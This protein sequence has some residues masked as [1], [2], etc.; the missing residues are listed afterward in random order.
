MLVTEMTEN[1]H[2]RSQ[3]MLFAISTP[4][5]KLFNV[6]EEVEFNFKRPFESH[7]KFKA[8]K[9]TTCSLGVEVNHAL[10]DTVKC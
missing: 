10:V 2:F 4:G 8:K 6:E 3:T 7:E 1:L 5:N 9:A